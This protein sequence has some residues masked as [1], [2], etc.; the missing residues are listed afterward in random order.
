MNEKKLILLETNSSHMKMD[1]WETT[2]I[3]GRPILRDYVSFR[4]GKQ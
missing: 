3:L 1:G 2:F 4:E